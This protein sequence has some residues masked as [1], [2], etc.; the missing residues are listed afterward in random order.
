MCC[1]FLLVSCENNAKS[2]EPYESKQNC[3]HCNSA[4]WLKGY[5]RKHLDGAQLQSEVIADELIYRMRK[6][7]IIDFSN[8]SEIYINKLVITQSLKTKIVA[9][10]EIE[11]QSLVDFSNQSTFQKK[12][13]PNT[14]LLGYQLS[15]IIAEDIAIRFNP[16]SQSKNDTIPIIMTASKANLL[17]DS[18]LLKLED[19]V[20]LKAK[21]CE[22]VSS[23]AIW[24]NKYRGIYFP[25]PF[26][27]NN[28]NHTRPTF[29]QITSNGKCQK[30]R[31]VY[32]IEYIDKLDLIEV[33]MF[34][35]MPI[36]IRLLFG[37]LAK[38]PDTYNGLISP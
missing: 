21:Q 22:L 36:K 5:S 7:K 13:A 28:K 2:Q 27:W 29:V 38:S 11:I 10:D 3:P 16:T 9:F 20:R 8:Y 6:G 18:M 17:T 37:I 34:E 26:L 14:T 35:L 32:S 23:T 19:K 31:S 33:K 1:V 12:T 15:R 30:L 25:H 24:S 4:F